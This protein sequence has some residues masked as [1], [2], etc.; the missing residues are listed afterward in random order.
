L[1]DN[2][3]DR[4]KR[5]QTLRGNYAAPQTSILHREAGQNM[6]VRNVSD[7]T[8][9]TYAGAGCDGQGGQNY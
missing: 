2:A 3:A 4:R 5:N 9:A 6:D 8:R 1:Y 7:D